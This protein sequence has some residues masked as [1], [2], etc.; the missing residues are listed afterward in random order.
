M[1]EGWLE[2]SPAERDL[3]VLVDSNSRLNKSQQRA[4]AAERANPILG[5]IKHSIT[6]Q[7]KEEIIRCVQHWCA[8]TSSTVCSSGPCN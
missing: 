6:S 5:C 3:G 8:L 4:L 2:S 7:S 1:G